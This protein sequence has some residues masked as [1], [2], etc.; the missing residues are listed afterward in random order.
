MKMPDYYNDYYF[1]HHE[2]KNRFRFIPKVELLLQKAYT[3]T[4]QWNQS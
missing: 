2:K 1:S 3:I 4:N